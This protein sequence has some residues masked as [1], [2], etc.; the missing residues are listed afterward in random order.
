MI[1][2]I[3]E[4]DRNE[5][6]ALKSTPNRAI[7]AFSPV[8]FAWLN[9]PQR[10]YEELE[11]ARYVDTMHEAKEAVYFSD[12]HSYSLDEA[13]LIGEISD[14]VAKLTL[15]RFGKSIRPWM[16][17]LA[18]IPLLRILCAISQA[19]GKKSL[20]VFEAGPGSGYLGALLFKAGH[21]YIS[22]DNTQAFYLWQNRLFHELAGKDFH[23]MAGSQTGSPVDHEKRAVHVPWWVYTT[24][25]QHC[26]IQADV[27]VCEQALG[28]ISLLGL[29]YMLRISARMLSGSHPGLFIFTSPGKTHV[30]SFRE[31][32]LEAEKAGL[33]P[34]F[35]K[36]FFGLT[37]KG[38]SLSR[39]VRSVNGCISWRHRLWEKA[40]GPISS[41]R[42]LR[43][44][45]TEILHLT[46][47]QLSSYCPSGNP[48]R[49]S[50]YEFVPIRREESP[51]DYP[52]ISFI[53]HAVPHE[54]AGE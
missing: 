36:H 2:P 10:V 33:V 35:A 14:T 52:F 27:V 16:A 39:F 49:L 37:P 5:R 9:Y 17:P 51:A 31:I 22:M 3:E 8:T 48:Q 44:A 24:F 20:T 43:S 53:G 7:Q 46:K 45:E 41:P 6:L 34:V 30:S 1:L 29:R 15:D 4:Y 40:I 12:T 42:P 25:H 28:E 23:E 26:P 50:A 38:S 19:T 21:R 32:F 54:K 11:L 47:K 13:R 18:S